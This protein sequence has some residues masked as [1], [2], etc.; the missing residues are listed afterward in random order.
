M[1]IGSELLLLFCEEK[2]EEYHKSDIQVAAPAKL[3]SQNTMDP[4]HINYVHKTSFG[5]LFDSSMPYGSWI[6]TDRRLSGYRLKVK[7][8]VVE[9]Y[10]ELLGE[11][12]D[13][14]Y[15]EHIFLFPN[16]SLTSFLGLFYSIEIATDLSN[17]AKSCRV[18]SIF[19]S[20]KGWW[21]PD[22]LR[23]ASIYAN[24]KILD[25]DKNLCETWAKTYDQATGKNWM[26][27]EERI[28]AY[29]GLL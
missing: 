29:L 22:P 5:R 12:V 25:E 26:P 20:R 15:F 2:G 18:V 27:G 6:T 9:R 19:Y 8:E 11:K 3:W 17:E 23:A 28:Q 24:N 1:V 13:R 21:I 10:R 7:D 14:D 16:L 4:H